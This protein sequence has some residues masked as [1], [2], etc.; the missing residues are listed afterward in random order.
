MPVYD[1]FSNIAWTTSWSTM[2]RAPER[3][4]A[5]LA[6]GYPRMPQF[7]DAF[8]EP[9]TLLKL[10][11]EE[12]GALLITYFNSGP[13]LATNL[14]VGDGSLDQGAFMNHCPEVNQ[15]AG[16]K[17]LT[18]VTQA[19][20]EGWAWLEREGLIAR[21]PNPNAMHFVIT[22]RGREIRT[23][24]D[25]ET[26]KRANLLRENS[27]HPILAQKVTS[28]FLRGDYDIA[29]LQAFKEVEVR[30]RIAGVCKIPTLA[31]T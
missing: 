31:Q 21:K 6:G 1:S 7:K 15:Y 29:V 18:Q 27:L 9:D 14:K 16:Q 11:P 8:P 4:V 12:V 23:H 5:L 25:A 24:A 13:Y 19:F 26:Y 3:A 10:E 2:D 28:L 22:R 17:P 20:L 30:V